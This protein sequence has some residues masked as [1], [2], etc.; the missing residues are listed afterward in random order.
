MYLNYIWKKQCLAYCIWNFAE[1]S[2]SY[3]LY[4]KHFNMVVEIMRTSAFGLCEMKSFLVM[5]LVNMNRDEEA[6]NTIKFWTNTFENTDSVTLATMTNRLLPGEW[7]HLP[8]QNRREI[9]LFKIKDS[10][11]FNYEEIVDDFDMKNLSLIIALMIIKARIITFENNKFDTMY[12][13]GCYLSKFEFDKIQQEALKQGFHI[14]DMV[15]KIGKYEIQQILFN[16][17]RPQIFEN[18]DFEEHLRCLNRVGVNGIT[19]IEARRFWHVFVRNS[20]FHYVLR[21]EVIESQLELGKEMIKND[22][23]GMDLRKLH[24]NVKKFPCV[25]L[26]EDIENQFEI[27]NQYVNRMELQKKLVETQIFNLA[28]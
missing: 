26:K 20:E 22:K 17:R 21:K 9:E 25:L 5:A 28:L 24:M 4:E 3:V 14:M 27:G 1:A 19:K 11:V 7:L 18:F 13:M 2:N 6:Y 23:K 10:F 16:E 8:N 15:L 12:S